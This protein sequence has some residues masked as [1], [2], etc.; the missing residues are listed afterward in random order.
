MQKNGRNPPPPPAVRGSRAEEAAHLPQ[1]VFA[2]TTLLPSSILTQWVGTQPPPFKSGGCPPQKSNTFGHLEVPTA[3][4][5]SLDGLMT[6]A[7][8]FYDPLPPG[9][10][11]K[12]RGN[13]Q[14][15]QM[16]KPIYT[17]ILRSQTP[18]PPDQAQPWLPRRQCAPSLQGTSQL[19]QTLLQQLLAVPLWNTDNVIHN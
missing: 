13:N 11:K 12:P 19:P 6:P 8:P 10:T 9:G 17:Q 15:S 7:P 18:P 4:S 1:V 16:L 2:G 14:I 3:Y 5:F